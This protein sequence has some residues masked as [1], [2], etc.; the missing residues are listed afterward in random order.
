MNTN[1]EHHVVIVGGGFGGL[2]AA[3]ALGNAPVKVTLVDK[4]NFH[5]FQ[6]LLYQVATG[7]LSPAEIAA[8]LRAIL[9]D[10]KNIKVIQ[11]QA[12]D[13]LPDQQKLILRDGEIPY[14]TLIVSTGSG[15]FYFGHD[16]WADLAPGLKTL[17]DAVEIRRRIFL[18][19]E[20]AER[21]P[22]PQERQAWMTFVVVGGGPT[23]VELAGAIGELACS[24][25]SGDFRH[26]NTCEAQI[27]LLEGLER[28]LPSYPP[29]LSQKAAEQL[30]PK[31]VRIRTNT[32]VTNIEGET[33]TVKH[34]GQEE[35]IQARTVL[36]GAGVKA[37]GM[38][39]V[40]HERMGAEVD[41]A[42]RVVVAPDLSVP[43][44]PNVFVIGDLALFRYQYD[45]KPVPG[46]A[47][48]AMQ[49]GRYVAHLIQQ[50]LQGAT[51][52][53]FRYADKGSLAVIGRNAAVAEIGELHFGG[54]PAW[55]IWVFIHLYYLIGFDR[56]VLVMF[57]WAWSYFT[58]H[59]GARLI[60]GA[61]ITTLVEQPTTAA[62]LAQADG[63][64]PDS[65]AT[66]PMT[67]GQ[68]PISVA[69]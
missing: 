11:G 49:E 14:D 31:G 66:A 16:E 44:H 21:A 54:Y 52:R 39:K 41:R 68:E 13:I 69:A 36:W 23:G 12:I 38:G 1:A 7:G 43:R 22:D 48:A 4:R 27:I 64:E 60:T 46:V 42:G 5:L 33:I 56:K 35:Y 67:D 2:Y 57:Q 32:L 65:G 53:P 24:T 10:Y 25:L 9:R 34:N 19:F 3:R 51:V 62:A 8:P 55:L 29:D 47:T 6:P 50:R 63:K 45:G 26:I 17:E 58:R 40:I 18:A 37:S 15:H 28:I 61:E 59:R 30:E 20:A